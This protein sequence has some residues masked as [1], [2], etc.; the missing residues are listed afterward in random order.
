MPRVTF[1][2][3]V[4]NGE[5][6][7]RYCLRALYPFAHQI[8]V[9]EGAVAAAAGIATQDGHSMDG[10][11]EALYRFK[12]EEDPGDKIQIVVRD[13]FWREKDEQSQAYAQRATGDYLWQVDI[14]EFYKPEDMTVILGML[15]NDSTITQV[16]VQWLNFW[17]SFDVL[18]DG[19]FLRRHYRDLG[20]GVPRLF[21][22]GPGYWYVTHRPP[23][24]VDAYSVDMRQGKWV[25]G[26]Q[27]ARTGT[28]CYHYATV[29]PELVERKMKYYQ[30]LGWERL[31]NFN[32]WYYNTFI[33]IRKPFRVHHVSSHISWLRPF[34]GTHP[35]QIEALADDLSIGMWSIK[36]RQ[37]D[38]VK[39]LMESRR[40]GMGVVL[41]ELTA[42]LLLGLRAL[43]PGLARLVEGSVERL[44]SPRLL[45]TQS[46]GYG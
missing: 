40:Y 3:I 8:I 44:F 29:F 11:L 26:D 43:S 45:A 12:D 41:L 33:R 6:F 46:K 28:Y 30:E 21:K 17:G 35:S 13:G 18:V 36:Q 19:L 5:P 38:D 22:W 2:I 1:G 9:V 20:G 4:L 32:D 25:R 37:D 14:D 42:T 39:P 16:S 24:V 27:L 7:T 23:T 10:T 15:A 34:R 31:G